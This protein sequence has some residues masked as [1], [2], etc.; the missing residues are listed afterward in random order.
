[1]VLKLAFNLFG[2]ERCIP[3]TDGMQ[4]MGLDD[5]I[6]TY[7]GI[8]YQAREGVARYKDGKL[9]G[10]AIGMNEILKRTMQYTGLPLPSIVKIASSNPSRL[11]GIDD[12][13]GSIEVGK[14]GD[15]VV[16]DENLSIRATI[17]NGR[18]VYS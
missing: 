16:F 9:I 10:T 8:E 5:G 1:V 2:A 3:I 6:Y 11:L 7:N 17:V 13:K 15:L 4:A 14:D 12:K 18:I